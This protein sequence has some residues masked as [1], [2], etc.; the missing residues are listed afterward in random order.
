MVLPAVTVLVEEEIASGRR[1]ADRTGCGKRSAAFVAVTVRRV[2]VSSFAIVRT[3][4][5]IV[6]FSAVYAPGVIFDV[7]CLTLI[8]CCKGNGIA[9]IRLLLSAEIERAV[10]IEN[11]PVE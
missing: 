10:A 3:P 9:V 5:A 1:N 11:T 8:I 6:D 4:L 7:V 2:A